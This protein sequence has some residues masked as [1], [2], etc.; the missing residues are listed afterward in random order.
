ML[1]HKTLHDSPLR[2]TSPRPLCC[3]IPCQSLASPGD[4]VASPG[5]QL[6]VLGPRK[7][8]LV[9]GGNPDPVMLMVRVRVSLWLRLVGLSDT[10]LQWVSRWGRVIPCDTGKFLPGVF[11]T[12][13]ILQHQWPWWTY[14]LYVFP[15]S[16]LT[17]L[18][19]RNGVRPVK[20][21]GVGLLVATF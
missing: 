21:L 9:F 6:V 17:W 18:V 3:T 4:N 15:F 11:L 5:L 1:P 2:P 14:T 13:T 8:P 16:A 20:K 12:V 10:P 19:D 7:K